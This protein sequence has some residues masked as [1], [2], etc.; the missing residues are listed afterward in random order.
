MAKGLYVGVIELKNLCPTIDGANGF[1][2]AAGVIE[3]STT[4]TKYSQNALKINSIEGQSEVYATSTTSLPLDPTHIYYTRIEAY[5]ETSYGAIEMYWPIAEPR[6]FNL[7]AKEAGKWNIYSA[8]VDRSAFTAGDYPFRLDFNSES[9][10][11]IATSAWYDG[12][13]I[14]DLTE[15]FGNGSEPTQEWCDENIPYF[16][17]IF[18]VKNYSG[19]GKARK[20][21][22]AYV[23]IIELKN[24]INDSSFEND[25][26]DGANYST[27]EKLY[28]NRSLYFPVDTTIVSNIEIERPV[29]GHIYYGRRYIKTNGNNTPADCRFEVWGADGENKN[30]VYA[31]NQGDYSEWGFDSAIH[32]I[33]S[34]DYP[35]T[36]RTIVRCF[37]VNTTADTWIDGV[38]LIDLTEAFGTGNEPTKEWC[39]ENIPYFENSFIVNNCSGIGKARKIKKGYIG[40]GGIARPFF[41]AEQKLTY[42]G[43]TTE[44][45]VAREN[46]AAATI[47]KYALFAGGSSSDSPRYATVDTYDKNLVKGVATDLSVAREDL[48]ATVIGDYALFAG[49]YYYNST[50]YYYATVDTYDKNLVKGTA[51]NLSIARHWMGATS[52]G[53]YALFGGGWDSNSDPVSTVETYDKNLVKGTATSLSVTRYNLAATSIGDYALFGGGS[54][55]GTAS[56]VVDTYD[57]NLVKGVAT[58]LTG[59]SRY[60]LAAATIGDYALF[61]GGYNSAVVDTYDKNLVKGVATDLTKG[62]SNLKAAI[63]GDYALFGGGSNSA[64]MDIYDKNLVKEITTMDLSK[65]RDCLAATSVGDYALFA[66]GN[67]YSLMTQYTGVV[68]VYQL[69]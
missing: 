65:F 6:P 37:N 26:W 60:S 48:T 1:N 45:S 46:L 57:K 49:G 39:D 51:T 58:N 62:R 36:D 28:G 21:K 27:S 22:K 32:K 40:I 47:G 35:E 8:V 69:V 61:A 33:T 63:V 25:K 17:D 20:V 68:D 66:G 14:I 18:T 3:S 31:W 9:N 4:H 10:N 38:M 23:G 5:Q 24:I 52:I 15:A 2:A 34:V 55:E 64:T 11:Y 29:I 42:Y 16:T 50:N 30:W 56:L 54:N 67:F 43:T 44:L 7:P 59:A 41:S 12:W 53:D 19:I 13:M